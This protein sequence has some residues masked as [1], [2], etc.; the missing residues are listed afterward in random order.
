LLVD[1][2]GMFSGDRVV[3]IPQV[4]SIGR[5]AVTIDSASKILSMKEVDERIVKAD[6]NK[7]SLTDT[8]VITESGTD[9]GQVS[10]IYFE[11]G[12]GKVIELEVSQGMLKTM[13]SGRKRI[14]VADISKIGKDATVV[15][16]FAETDFEKQ[17]SESG[18]QGAF[19]AVTKSAPE[20]VDRAKEQISGVA[21]DVKNKFDEFRESPKTQEIIYD[22]KTKANEVKGSL[23]TTGARASENIRG[24]DKRQLARD[25]S[26]RI[27]KAAGEIRRKTEEIAKEIGESMSRGYQYS[28]GGMAGPDNADSDNLT[29]EKSNFKKVPLNQTGDIDNYN[30][31]K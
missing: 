14:K 17:A 30:D 12:S 10:D 1:G 2:K 25:T 11:P 16:A 24:T 29:R 9:L 7:H 23:V 8:K 28:K 13:Q 20:M 31:K 19:N 5:D 18:M 21:D 27:G 3:L 15:R 6:K 4:H 26:M 22:M